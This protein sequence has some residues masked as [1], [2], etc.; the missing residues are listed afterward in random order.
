MDMEEVASAESERPI[1]ILLS[2]VLVVC[3]CF[4]SS[5]L[6]LASFSS[7]NETECCILGLFL[8][9][10]VVLYANSISCSDCSSASSSCSSSSLLSSSPLSSCCSDGAG[11]SLSSLPSSSSPAPTAETTSSNLTS[12]ELPGYF[13]LAH[14]TMRAGTPT[15]V[16]PCGTGRN[17][18][19]PAPILAPSPT[20]IFPSTCV[21]APIK[22]WCPT[23]GCR[24]LPLSFPV[25][26]KVTPCRRVH[27]SPML[28]VS[29]TTMPV[30]WSNIK[31]Q[32]MAAAG[33]ISTPKAEDAWDW[34]HK[35]TKLFLL[36]SVLERCHW[37]CATR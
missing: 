11:W 33:C 6:L 30:A 34:I 22:T 10:E 17:T 7:L 8:S 13:S 14:P 29:P 23:L 21:P 20:D 27:P 9:R 37:M 36:F 18:T 19:L 32:P 1:F 35:L 5:P 15:A 24:S 26:P 12:T 2:N 31:P 3:C 25:P 16:V 4:V 28:A